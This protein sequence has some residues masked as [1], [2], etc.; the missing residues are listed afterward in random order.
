VNLLVHMDARGTRLLIPIWVYKQLI[1][2]R[3]GRDLRCAARLIST[4]ALGLVTAMG[5]AM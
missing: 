3:D 5:S 4:T 1:L 2:W